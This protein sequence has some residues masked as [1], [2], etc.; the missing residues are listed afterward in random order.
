MEGRREEKEGEEG[1]KGGMEERKKG[2]VEEGERKE[3][4]DLSPHLT[5]KKEQR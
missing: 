5:L 4:R 2:R 1:R 3:S